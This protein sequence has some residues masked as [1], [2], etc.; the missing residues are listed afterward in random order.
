MAALLISVEWTGPG[1]AQTSD[2]PVIPTVTVVVTSGAC[3]NDVVPFTGLVVAQEDV[4]VIP[5]TEGT[6]VSEVLVEEGA[7]VTAGQVL[8]R[9]TSLAPPQPGAPAQTTLDV[10]APV[11][12]VV[13]ARGARIGALASPQA[14][15]PLFRLA[16]DGAMEVVAG[17]PATRLTN[18]R[19]GQ[20]A[21][22][23]IPGGGETLGH[24]RHIAPEIDR[25]SRLGSVRISIEASPRLRFGTTVAGAVDT[26]RSC[27]L[28]VPVSA[29]LAQGERTVVQRVR[30]GR[31]EI[32]PV[33]LGFVQ[34]AQAEIREGL[35]A[36]DLVVARAAAFLS[37]GDPVRTMPTEVQR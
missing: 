23:Q 7:R 12:G 35:N 36:G 8:A 5:E 13:I 26:G 24:V 17:L 18:L 31:V 3:F 4:L 22:V 10:F 20:A 11:N 2:A 25:Q 19:A 9:L 30:D 27:G 6:R 15:E 21:R 16:R 28:A 37:A 29:L 32:A 33:Q 14:P 1:V 34:G